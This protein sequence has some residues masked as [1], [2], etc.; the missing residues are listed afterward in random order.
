MNKRYLL[1]L[2]LALVLCLSGCSQ[3]EPSGQDIVDIQ[4]TEEQLFDM[5]ITEDSLFLGTQY[6]RGEP[7]QLRQHSRYFDETGQVIMEGDVYLYRKDGSRELLLQG[8][9]LERLAFGRY[10]LDEQGRLYVFQSD[11]I[12]G[13][14]S[15]GEERFYTKTEDCGASICQLA[16]GRILTEM[17]IDGVK[18][19][20]TV[21][22]LTGRLEELFEMEASFLLL[23][24]AAE[25]ALVLGHEGLYEMSLTDG[26]RQ[27][28]LRWE[29]TSY[30][31][32]F[33]TDMQA[34]RRLEDGS[35]EILLTDGRA[36]TLRLV[37]VGEDRILLT[38]RDIYVSAW[39]K[40]QIVE[41]NKENKTYYVAVEEKPE[42]MEINT[43]RERTDM[44]IATGGGADI[45][46]SGAANSSYSLLKKGA[47]ADLA[48]Y[49]KKTGL[50][51]EDYFPFTFSYWQIG[52]ALYAVN[53]IEMPRSIWMDASVA[54]ESISDIQALVD[55]LL[56][57]EKEAVFIE[58]YEAAGVLRYFL[59]G[60]EDLWGMVD[61]EKGTCD[62]SGDLFAGMME[63]AARYGDGEY[64]EKPAIAGELYWPGYKGYIREA[65]IMQEAG[66][67]VEAGYL[68]DDGWHAGVVEYMLTINANSPNKE[69][70]WELISFLMGS[71]AQ[72]QISRMAG[73]FPVNRAAYDTVKGEGRKEMAAGICMTLELV[74]G[75][76]IPETRIAEEMEGHLEAL[77]AK[78]EDARFFPL[79]TEPVLDIILEEAESYFSGM[80]SLEE[81][82]DVMENRIG[83]YLKEIK[84]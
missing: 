45:I 2:L 21:D 40:E 18:K 52:E 47:F 27:Y 23:S 32:G 54:G 22:P 67:R 14:D 53:I 30:T 1:F 9:P 41:F 72:E 5:Q 33:D 17:V 3:K 78:I 8:M 84:V 58:G 74:H 62:L 7:V 59:R 69:G 36:E 63:A 71:K 56:A 12:R 15:N 81:V 82:I 31:W 13:L 28:H 35:V 6:Y 66:G 80:K 50:K 76:S 83:L 42:G 26:S 29:G 49:I 61:W 10:W 20:V 37:Q 70:A 11:G 64:N 48:P 73:Q 79:E 46:G 19:L 44:E 43:F 68:F 16:D 4:V 55:N 25:G 38:L 77:T 34:F 75:I 51:E 65:Y 39:L 60:S 24:D 57:Y